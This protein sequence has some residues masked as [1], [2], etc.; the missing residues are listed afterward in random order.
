[1][2]FR[3]LNQTKLRKPR[4]VLK[5]HFFADH[6][7]PN[8]LG[9]HSR[10]PCQAVFFVKFF[11]KEKENKNGKCVF[12]PLKQTRPRHPGFRQPAVEPAFPWAPATSSLLA[13]TVTPQGK[14]TEGSSTAWQGQR[15][16]QGSAGQGW[17]SREGFPIKKW[18]DGNLDQTTCRFNMM[19]L[20]YF[21]VGDRRED[22][23]GS[24]MAPERETSL[25]SPHALG[26]FQMP[27]QASLVCP[28]ACPNPVPVI[29]VLLG[30]LAFTVNVT[31]LNCLP[32]PLTFLLL[33]Q[34]FPG[35]P[36]PKVRAFWAMP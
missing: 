13:A 15:Q 23:H 33:P 29:Q 10:N 8:T 11:Y 20:T 1:M 34:G 2:K 4:N 16:N 19:P 28:L 18:A 12:K 9:S 14:E 35:P 6:P 36:G 31:S 7:L 22:A 30:P 21:P 27:Y 3:E 25:L 5:I 32:C 17:F 24:H 26:R